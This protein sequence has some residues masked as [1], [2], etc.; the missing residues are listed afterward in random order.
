MTKGVSS[1]VA[2]LSQVSQ[3]LNNCT[4]RSLVLLDEFGKGTAAQ[5]GASLFAATIRQLIALG[6]NCPRT[7]ATTHFHEVFTLTILP[8]NTPT[9]GIYHMEILTNDVLSQVEPNMWLAAKPTPLIFLFQLRPGRAVE[10]HAIHC[11]RTCGLPENIIE[12]ANYVTQL[13]QRNE[14]AVLQLDA[15]HGT[16]TKPSD[17]Y[18]E[19]DRDVTALDLQY[20]SPVAM[21]KRA[22]GR[23]RCFVEWD[24]ENDLQ[25]LEKTSNEGNRS[26]CQ[27]LSKIFSQGAAEQ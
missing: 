12:R 5:D 18:D 2:D 24:I 9:M 4:S 27:K 17:S 26:A 3:A 15:L 8:E 22:E 10:S 25:E 1:F 20:N 13:A 7:I 6:K 21:A 23:L 14:L 19:R 16:T 11:A